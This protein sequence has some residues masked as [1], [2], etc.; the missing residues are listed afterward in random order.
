MQ[1]IAALI[2]INTSIN[3]VTNTIA[4]GPPGENLAIKTIFYINP[5]GENPEPVTGLKQKPI[6]IATITVIREAGPEQKPI[7]TGTAIIG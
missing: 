5:I 1:T 4:T 2:A 7:N 6:D 3:A